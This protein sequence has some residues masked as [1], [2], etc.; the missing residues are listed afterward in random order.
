MIDLLRQRHNGDRKEVLE[1][2]DVAVGKPQGMT[3]IEPIDGEVQIDVEVIIRIVVLGL[4]P[5][6][7]LPDVDLGILKGRR[8]T[9]GRRFESV[10]VH[11]TLSDCHDVLSKVLAKREGFQA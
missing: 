11:D 9:N 8:R 5:L 1:D 10:K 4:D 3:I 6:E 2:V 7:F